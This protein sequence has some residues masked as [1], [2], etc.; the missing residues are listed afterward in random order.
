MAITGI[1]SSY[2]NVY[3]S[4]YA[5][6]KKETAKK[7]EMQ[8]A[9]SAQTGNAKKAG[10]DSVSDYYSYLQKNYDCMSS[11]NVT[12]SSAYLKK[13]SGNSAKAKELEDFLKKI[14]ELEKQ[15][16]EQLSAQNKAL[17]GT[18]TY[19]QQTWMVNKDGSIQSTVYS[20]TETGMTNAERMKKNIDE[21][22]EKQKEK[23]EEEEKA[24]EEK[25]ETAE[26]VEKLNG[27]TEKISVLETTEQEIFV[28]YVKAESELDAKT[29]MQKEKME[30]AYYPKFDMN[31]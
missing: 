16:Y 9:A 1:E 15:G 7:A 6:Q 20:V 29:M 4:T 30:D 8:E 14:P 18:V 22:L 27:G 21:Q 24:K 31:V 12:I 19:Y 26:Q 13:C 23:K 28:K 2:S 5:A 25:E 11:G 3:E 17:G 10:T